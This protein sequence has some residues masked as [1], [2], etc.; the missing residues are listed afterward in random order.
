MYCAE[1]TEGCSVDSVGDNCFKE[2]DYDYTDPYGNAL[3]CK[4]KSGYE[5]RIWWAAEYDDADGDWPTGE[6]VGF[7]C[8]LAHGGTEEKE[9]RMERAGFH[10][11]K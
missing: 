2:P 5:K 7:T 11:L 8:S 10:L 1:C 3:Q 4:C 9:A 6:N